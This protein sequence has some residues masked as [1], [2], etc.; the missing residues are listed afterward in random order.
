MLIHCFC[1]MNPLFKS[2]SERSMPT[3]PIPWYVANAQSSQCS[4]K[5]DASSVVEPHFTQWY[6]RECAHA[7]NAVD[8]NAFRSVIKGIK[9]IRNG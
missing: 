4:S 3:K 2:Q 7:Q 1:R 6:G 9:G 8:G 5:R